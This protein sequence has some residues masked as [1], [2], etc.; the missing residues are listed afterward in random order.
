MMGNE[1]QLQTGELMEQEEEDDLE[2]NEESSSFFYSS[3]RGSGI[4]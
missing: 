1:D 4:F 2:Q 3:P